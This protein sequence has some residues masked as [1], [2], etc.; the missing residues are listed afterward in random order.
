VR[1]EQKRLADALAQKRN[2][3]AIEIFKIRSFLNLMKEHAGPASATLPNRSSSVLAAL[4]R[5]G[6]D[7][8]PGRSLEPQLAE[9]EYRLGRVEATAARLFV[10]TTGIATAMRGNERELE[11]L[12]KSLSSETE[13]ALSALKSFEQAVIL[14]PN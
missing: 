10:S 8:T 1:W 9:L 4:I 12:R 7:L 6:P 2:A 13:S 5:L 3:I 11:E 14:V